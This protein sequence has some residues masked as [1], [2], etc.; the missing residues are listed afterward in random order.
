MI[1]SHKRKY[2]FVELPLTG[3]TAISRELRENYDG[4]EYLHKHATYLEF[5]RAATA[6]ERTYFVFS[7]IR[8]PMDVAVS[9]YFKYRTNHKQRFTDKSRLREHKILVRFDDLRKFRFI[10]K[11]EASFAE[12]FLR[13]YCL[14]YNNWSQLSHKQFDFILRFESL[15][16]DFSEVLRRLG[17]QQVQPLPAVNKTAEKGHF[18]TYYTPETFKRARRVFGPFLEKWGYEFPEEWG[19]VKISW[20]SRVE[21]AACNLPRQVYWRFLRGKL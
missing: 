14:P 17:L 15:Q 2:L 20:T 12:F 5:L 7:N 19:D 16:A 10:Q 4:V 6:E 1:I 21:F 13:F 3:T 11:N 9:L 8:N 18:L